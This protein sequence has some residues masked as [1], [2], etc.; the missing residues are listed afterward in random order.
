MAVKIIEDLTKSLGSAIFEYIILN[1]TG[2]YN[3]SYNF[4]LYLLF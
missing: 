1:D 4:K 3:V 2:V